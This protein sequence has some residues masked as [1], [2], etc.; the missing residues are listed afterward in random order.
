MKARYQRIYRLSVIGIL[1]VGLC[2]GCAGINQK[3]EDAQVAQKMKDW[4]AALK[5]KLS[6]DDPFVRRR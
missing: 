5:N 3:I 2:L 6:F 4:Q 1:L